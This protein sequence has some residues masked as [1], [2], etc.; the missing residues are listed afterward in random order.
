M[1]VYKHAGNLWLPTDP[2]NV[3]YHPKLPPGNYAVCFNPDLGGF[4]LEQS[5][6]FTYP[7]K[8]YGEAMSMA[9]R[10][11]RTYL[12]RLKEQKLSTGVLLSG[13]KGSGKTLISKLIAQMAITQGLPV[14]LIGAG[15]EGAVFNKF[16]QD[17]NQPAVVFFDE[18]E[19]M[20]KNSYFDQEGSAVS[21]GGQDAL[22]SLFDGSQSTD[23]LFLLTANDKFGINRNMINRP[24]RIYYF[25]EFKGLSSLFIREYCDENLANK[26]H[27]E[28]VCLAASL[29]PKFNFD[30]LSAMVEEMNRYKETASQVM[31]FINTQP[32]EYDSTDIYS[33]DLV[34]GGESIATSLIFSGGT[35]R[36]NP[37]AEAKF[38]ISYHT[39]DAEGKILTRENKCEV[40]FITELQN[41][42]VEE[43]IYTLVN[44][45]GSVLT[46]TYVPPTEFN[47]G[48]ID[49]IANA[50]KQSP[51]ALAASNKGRK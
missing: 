24:G 21:G 34:V 51:G 46:L 18:F 33:I 16:I 43:R 4:Y 3:E 12:H 5:A 49:D 50:Y 40:F 38:A 42:K 13:E 25:L 29:F 11:Y 23:K 39:T 44:K 15:F 30:M 47:V 27:V 48:Q 17:I 22:L 7:S 8:L 2:V 19:K 1:S 45:A 10:I 32:N 36:C 37:V 9:E 28:S 41:V 6:P 26:S 20:Y 35:M 14:I 31:K